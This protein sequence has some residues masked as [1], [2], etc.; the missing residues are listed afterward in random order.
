[1]TDVL[2]RQLRRADGPLYRQ[3]AE[4]LRAAIGTTLALGDALPT[5][6]ELA[7][8]F[9]ISLITVRHALR[10]L[11]AE[12][13]IRKRPAK[14][15]IVAS[16]T[17]SVAL[18]RPLNS[19]DDIIAGTE[20]ARLDI[21]RY[22]P[23]RTAEAAALF[24]L[25]PGTACPCLSARLWQKDEPQADITIFFPPAIGERLSREDF[26]DV[27]V[28]RS[29]ER[30]LGIRIAAARITITAELADAKLARA[31]G[32]TEGAAVLVSR[33]VYLDDGGAPVEFTIARHRADR[34]SLT[35]G[36]R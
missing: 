18:P 17:P 27:V 23:R 12:G 28:F 15:A 14:T 31:L 2:T 5:E 35:Y 11:E 1:M 24:A 16:L 33:M 30:R 20:G 34:Y 21:L 3:A 26:D 7:Q 13:L 22:Q 19:L 10:E 25:P 29:V 36:F 6:A 32:T 4:A 9:G 8:G